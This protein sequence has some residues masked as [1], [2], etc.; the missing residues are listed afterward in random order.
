MSRKLPLLPTLI[1]AAAVA[2]M[3]ALGFWQLGRARERDRLHQ[4]LVERLDLPLVEYPFRNPTDLAFLYRRVTASCSEVRAWQTRAGE[5]VTGITGWRHI[6]TCVSRSGR[7][8]LMVDVGTSSAP[9]RGVSWRG[10]TVS[11]RAIR[12][13]DNRSALERLFRHA[14]ERRLMIVSERPA[15]GLAPSKQPDPSD[16]A[17]SS[18]SYTV[19]WF[20]FAATAAMIYVLALRKRWRG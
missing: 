5:T 9:G 10:G 17:N 1:V 2:T 14:P 7:A 18:W 8:P 15:Q 12:E 11:G 13:P 6:A 3:I 16:D 4:Q 19:Q 20:L